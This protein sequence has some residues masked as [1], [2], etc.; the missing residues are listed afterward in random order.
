MTAPIVSLGPIL[1]VYILGKHPDFC[2][3]LV[4][5][6]RLVMIKVDNC[7]TVFVGTNQIQE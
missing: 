7:A 3:I 5:A 4:L 6:T 2:D 1:P